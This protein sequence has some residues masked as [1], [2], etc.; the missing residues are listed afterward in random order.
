MY[1]DIYDL[2]GFKPL[3]FVFVLFIPCMLSLSLE[4]AGRH[5]RRC[6]HHGP[7]RKGEIFWVSCAT[8]DL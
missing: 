7:A 6:P 3:S 2:I 5:E 8:D 1:V 4:A